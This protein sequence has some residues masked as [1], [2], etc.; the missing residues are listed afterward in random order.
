MTWVG[1]IVTFALV[2]NVI[3]SRLLGVNASVQ[4][5]SG[6]GAAA[7]MGAATA[8]LMAGGALA[9]WAL[10]TLVLVPAGY[11]FLRT[12]AFV[13]AVAGLAFALHAGMRRLPALLGP[14]AALSMPEVTVNC[15]ALGVTLI[16]VR[17][18]YA[19]GECLVAGLAAGLGYF[20]VTA[21]MSA[22]TE[23]LDVERAPRALAGLPLRLVSAGLLAYAFMAFDRAFL[24]RVLG[25]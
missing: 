13:L 14:S 19:A 2:D 25:G 16:A 4:R 18:G 8:V 12:P 21:I 20:I 5:A 3:L 15:A 11:T 1:I 7:V 17:G 22:I 23:R 6:I 9:G 24:A 10:D